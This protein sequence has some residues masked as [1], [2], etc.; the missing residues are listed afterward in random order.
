M[1]NLLKFTRRKAE[2]QPPSQISANADHASTVVAT[3]YFINI[4]KWRRIKVKVWT[5]DICYSPAYMSQTRH[6]QRFTISEVAADWHERAAIMYRSIAKLVI[7][8]SVRLS[9]SVCV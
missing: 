6:Q 5:L 1:S 9:V 7:F 4:G 8:S 3:H 2:N